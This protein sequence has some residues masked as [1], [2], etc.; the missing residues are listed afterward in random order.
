MARI[1]SARNRPIIAPECGGHSD[2]SL[3]R[4][5][6]RERSTGL[7][8]RPGEPRPG[9]ARGLQD[10]GKRKERHVALS[11]LHPADVPYLY[12]VSK[13]DGTHLFSESLAEHNQAVKTYQPVREPIPLRRKN[14]A[15][16]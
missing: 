2:R 12:F 11:A 3:P 4:A 16:R 10:A 14:L 1:R 9:D 13:D 6:S 7:V 5:R 8:K 15:R